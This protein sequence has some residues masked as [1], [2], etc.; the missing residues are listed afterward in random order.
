MFSFE[1]Y[2][3]WVEIWGG[4]GIDFDSIIIIVN[5]CFI[6]NYFFL[7]LINSVQQ[8]VVVVF[9]HWVYMYIIYCHL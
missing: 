1:I 4:G 9:L 6:S 2:F 3:S 5:I 7:A 8:Y